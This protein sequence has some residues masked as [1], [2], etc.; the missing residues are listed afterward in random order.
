MF[1]VRATS[2][3]NFD[4]KLL[5]SKFIWFIYYLTCK[6]L[7]RVY[8]LARQNVINFAYNFVLKYLSHAS[9]HF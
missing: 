7:G 3:K 8:K 6:H 9:D 4:V 2:L 1:T 5:T